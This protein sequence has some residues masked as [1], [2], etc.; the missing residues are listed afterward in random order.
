MAYKEVREAR[1]VKKQHNNSVKPFA[2]LT[3]TF[4][5]LHLLG[6]GFSIVARASAPD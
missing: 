6:H 1:V 2:T 3:P 4:S 5:T